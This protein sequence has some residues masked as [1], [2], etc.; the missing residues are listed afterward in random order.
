MTARYTAKDYFRALFEEELSE[1]AP[2]EI[3]EFKYSSVDVL[4][5]MSADDYQSCFLAWLDGRKQ[6]AKSRA[7]EF[8]EENGCLERFNRLHV[9]LDAGSV[10]PFVGAGMSLSSGF[11]LWG[12][13]LES[14][15][16]DYEDLR[17]TVLQFIEHWRY[18]EAAQ[19]IV[20]RIGFNSFTESIENTFGSRRN[21]VSGPIQLL[22]HIFKRGCITTNFDYLLDRIF[23]DCDVSFAQTFSGEGLRDAPRRLANQPHC[24]LRLH[25]EAESGHGRVLTCNEYQSAYGADGSYKELFSTLIAN[26]SLLFLGCSLSF[27]R[28]VE[29]LKEIHRDARVETPRHYAFLALP[30]TESDRQH[31]RDELAKANIFPIWYPDGDHDDAIE[32]LLIALMEGGL[33]D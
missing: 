21:T 10:I 24:L 6:E 16:S 1:S 22:P 3:C 2:V 18:E 5:S 25:G 33:H 28:T 31:R 17:Q 13:F 30:E 7:R 12:R 4:R 8:L 23:D 14:I 26:C 15:S 29:A 11:P 20:D 32:C 19:A 9:Q 27:D